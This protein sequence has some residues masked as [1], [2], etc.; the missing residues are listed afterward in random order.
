MEERLVAAGK[1]PT[2][3]YTGGVADEALDACKDSHTAG[4]SSK[5]KSASDRFDDKGVFALVCRHDIPLCFANVADP[6]E[7]QKYM[8]ASLEWLFEHLPPDATVAGF[9][10]VGCI[11]DRTRQLVRSLSRA[12]RSPTHAFLLPSTMSS[13]LAF[14]SASCSS[15]P[16]CTPTRINGRV[17]SSTTHA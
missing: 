14:Q 16:P 2:R 3:Q 9:Y 5:H 12:R 7:G 6:G 4:T 10:D 15:R 13:K 1:R 8:L 17:K 11:T